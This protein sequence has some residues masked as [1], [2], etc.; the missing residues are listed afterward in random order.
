MK[1]WKVMTPEEYRRDR[2]TFG[3]HR[4]ELRYGVRDCDESAEIHV[5]LLQCDL[6]DN[7]AEKEKFK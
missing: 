2:L 3:R 4:A 6:Y 7:V 5:F 1:A